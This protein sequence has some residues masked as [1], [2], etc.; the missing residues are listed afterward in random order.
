MVRVRRSP[1]SVS[2]DFSLILQALLLSY[3]HCYDHVPRAVPP[4]DPIVFSS[5][6]PGLVPYSKTP[7]AAVE[8]QLLRQEYFC[9][10]NETRS[11]FSNAT[12]VSQPSQTNLLFL[13]RMR[14]AGS[15]SLSDYLLNVKRVC[16]SGIP[17]DATVVNPVLQ[18][19]EVEYDAVNANCF[20]G[21][22]SGLLKVSDA[23]LITHLRHP[24]SRI[25][26]EFWFSGP[27]SKHRFVN[28][29]HWR[30]W[31]EESKPR[32]DGIISKFRGMS[33]SKFYASTYH[34]NYYVRLF[35]NHC[36]EC[37][38]RFDGTSFGNTSVDGCSV[39]QS[40]HRYGGPLQHSDLDI[41]KEVLD[42]FDL[43]LITEWFK[44][45]ALKV[46]LVRRLE[47]ALNVEPQS[48]L[49]RRLES[50]LPLNLKRVTATKHTPGG[51][52]D[53]YRLA[54]PSALTEFLEMD[55]SLDL[56][57]YAHAKKRSTHD[58]QPYREAESSCRSTYDS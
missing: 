21:H 1:I 25:N 30:A 26:S 15:T 22:G 3:A 13:R 54:P 41:A 34:D 49:A 50:I 23:F 11:F 38:K 28:D 36:G 17:N 48:L 43:V 5:A 37:T 18:L 27:G 4:T 56:E 46:L 10:L 40:K 7:R 9:V 19:D 51:G 6:F 20:I 58:L 8:M 44:D 42:R 31:I 2:L 14:K 47:A 57:F 12:S 45:P 29:S 32:P 52:D 53:G 39:R 16:N 33:R 55:N 24:I 35:S